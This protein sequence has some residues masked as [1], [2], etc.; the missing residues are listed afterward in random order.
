MPPNKEG[1]GCI[2]RRT[3]LIMAWWIHLDAAPA[4]PAFLSPL[5]RLPRPC[6]LD[7]PAWL[8][9]FSLEE[10]EA[11][12]LEGLASEATAAGGRVSRPDKKRLAVECPQRLHEPASGSGFE[13]YRPPDLANATGGAEGLPQAYIPESI[14]PAWEFL[15]GA[16]GKGR[17]DASDLWSHVPLPPLRFFLRDAEEVHRVYNA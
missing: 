16:V 13:D 10:P 4:P 9:D 6:D 2:L 8:S 7:A 3:T 5:M 1:E 17:S 14:E 11:W 12:R 15:G